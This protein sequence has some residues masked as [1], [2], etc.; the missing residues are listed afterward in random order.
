MRDYMTR[1]LANWSILFGIV[2]SAIG[3]A[4]LGQPVSGIEYEKVLLPS[5]VNVPLPG[6]FGS[7]WVTRLTVTNP[8]SHDIDEF[9][10]L[11]Y[12]TEGHQGV[13]LMSTPL[14]ANSSVEVSTLEDDPGVGR[15]GIFYFVDRRFIDQIQ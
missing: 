9:Y 2:C 7:R 10:A 8:T 14:P 12:A 3:P 15:R 6:S 13:Q 11:L 4:L 5:V 1:R